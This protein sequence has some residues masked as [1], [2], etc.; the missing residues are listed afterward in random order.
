MNTEGMGALAHPWGTKLLGEAGGA[1]DCA[2]IKDFRAR[3]RGVVIK[4]IRLVALVYQRAH[5]PLQRVA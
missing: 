2:A 1:T 4:G 3:H 5:Q